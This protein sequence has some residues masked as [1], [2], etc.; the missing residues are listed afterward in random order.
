MVCA[1]LKACERAGQWRRALSLLDQARAA[2]LLEY[3]ATTALAEEPGPGAASWPGEVGDQDPTSSSP[4]P[5]SALPAILPYNMVLASL[6]RG[7]QWA[8][9]L[10]LLK[11]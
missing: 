7:G 5:S 3:P 10:A 2:G 1:A 6:A 8:T 9:A 4:P 11:V